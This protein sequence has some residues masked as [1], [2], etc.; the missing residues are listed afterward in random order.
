MTSSFNLLPVL[1][2]AISPSFL[3]LGKLIALKP[4]LS[5]LIEAILEKKRPILTTGFS[6]PGAVNDSDRMGRA[7]GQCALHTAQKLARRSFV[8]LHFE[9]ILVGSLVP[10]DILARTKFDVAALDADM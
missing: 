7:W 2:A 3:T 8:E 10:K 1:G 9:R 6:L 5:R 4:S